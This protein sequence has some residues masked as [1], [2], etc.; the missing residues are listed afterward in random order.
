MKMVS[1]LVGYVCSFAQCGLSNWTDLQQT[2]MY[3]QT[4][5]DI[6]NKPKQTIRTRDNYDAQ[7]NKTGHSFETTYSR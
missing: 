3:T 1:D 2:Q 7:G 6:A 5:R 4:Q